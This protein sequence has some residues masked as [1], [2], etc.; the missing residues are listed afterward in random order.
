MASRGSRPAVWSALAAMLLI[1]CSSDPPGAAPTTTL[2][3]TTTSP[4][5][6][7]TSTSTTTTTM[8]ATTTTEPPDPYASPGWLAAENQRAG[9]SDWR[10]LFD[11]PNPVADT[12]TAW[13]EGFADTTSAQEGQTVT[14]F[15]DTPAPTFVVKAFRMGWY[16]GTQGRLV[17]QSD[18]TTGQR[19]PAATW[20]GHT[21]LSEAPWFPSLTFTID[22]GWP[23]GAYLLKLESS[24][25][26]GHYVPLTIRHDAAYAPLLFMNA[27][28]TWQAYNPWGG[29]T[30]YECFPPRTK[31]RGEVVSF[32]RPYA[33]SY[34]Q[35]AADFPSHELPLISFI[36]EQGYDVA[37]ITNV[38]LHRD[39]TLASSRTTLISG[40]H[41]EYY[42]WNMRSGLSDA[43]AKGTNLAFFGA[44]AVYRNIR[45]EPGATGGVDRRFANFRVND[46]GAHGD[47]TLVTVNWR[48]APLKKPE[49]EIVGIQYGCAQVRAN[50]RLVNTGSWFYEGTG[51]KDGQRLKNLVGTEF[52]E[53][54]PSSETPAGLE[55]LS[56]TPLQCNNLTYQ[57]VTA[58]HSTL[59]GGGVFA[60]GT[61]DW[62]CGLDGSCWGIERFDIV[63][64]VTA[65]VLRAFAAGPAGLTHPGNGNAGHY[66]VKVHQPVKPKH[67][68]GGVKPPPTTDPGTPTTDPP[69]DPPAGG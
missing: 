28:T 12:P 51:A 64:G 34:A 62:N 5:T 4:A 66:R 30:L 39:P 69:P 7:T 16:G 38:D 35:G 10:I 20:D 63:R 36:E 6:T 42:S 29:C 47:P 2:L 55:V 31:F 22:R 15:V 32:D 41:D 40:G 23:P 11:P 24:N 65:S 52:D 68:G 21:G 13:I 54:A 44:N 37:Y 59:S 14:L 27:V 49:A 53:L 19:Q 61:I 58:Y 57:G 50:M 17:W 26:G 9:S 46:P 25:G 60:A 48:E 8:A 56:A 1:A 18:A 45:F 43:T 3:A 33:H 67:T